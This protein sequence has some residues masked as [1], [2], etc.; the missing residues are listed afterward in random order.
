MAD[1]KKC[2]KCGLPLSS[3][4]EGGLC[5]A[6]LLKQGLQTNTEGFSFEAGKAIFWTPPQPE[7]LAPLFPELD[8][9]EF[10]GRGGM[11]AV[12][13]A[14]EKQLDRMVALKILPPEI[15]RQEAFAQRFAREAQS[16]ARLSHPSIVTIHSF[17][18]R[19]GQ[20]FAGGAGLYFFIMEYVDGLSLRQLLDTG[21][22]S[23]K[24][25]LAIVPQI[26]DA[27]QYAH[28]RGIV[29]RDVK[30][31]NIL[32]NRAG[33]V[34]I[35][36]FGL[37]KLV[38]LGASGG[39]IP[40]ETP[41]QPSTGQEVT[42]AGG[43]MG[44]PQYMAPEQLERPQEVDSRADIYSLG[45]VF[46]QMLTG[47]LPKGRFEPPSRKVVIDVRL[48]EVVLRALEREPA[49]RYQQA[50]EVRTQ[51]ET[52]ARTQG[53]APGAQLLPVEAH[54]SRTAIIGAIWAGVALAGFSAIF[55]F[56]AATKFV[57]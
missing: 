36:D 12:Y 4:V 7:H 52:I 40:S 37:A 17:G 16:M 1:Q 34:K 33:Q 39:A 55:F 46:Y 20:G 56:Y 31:E 50:S 32:L 49:R 5:P 27:L 43:V 35:A 10:I 13:K 57:R 48:D 21:E 26:C 38:G 3:G 30:P 24:E 42:L 54:F 28:D 22:V 18:Q 15:G 14:R 8:I 45:V 6:C 41:G 29:H 19:S 9:I 23:P 51:V 2:A 44:T 47:E 25:A 53:G 11:G